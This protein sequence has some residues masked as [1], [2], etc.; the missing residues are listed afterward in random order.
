MDRDNIRSP[1]QRQDDFQH[2]ARFLEVFHQAIET[3]DF[4][5]LLDTIVDHG[6]QFG[7]AAAGILYLY[8]ADRDSYVAAASRG[9]EVAYDKAGH[10]VL[11]DECHLQLLQGRM[12]VVDEGQRWFSQAAAEGFAD[13]SSAVLI[14]FLWQTR[15]TAVLVLLFSVTR[16]VLPDSAAEL[17][18]F[19]AGQAAV[20]IENVRLLESEQQRRIEAEMLRSASI[21]IT[22]TLSLEEVLDNILINL[23]KVISYDRAAVFLLNGSHLFAQAC[24]GF[25]NPEELIGK[26]FPADDEIFQ[27]IRQSGKSLILEDARS[28]P[29]FKGWAGTEQICSWMG[30]PLLVNN[31]TIGY[32]TCDSFQ[33]GIYNQKAASVA[34]AFANQAAMSITNA[35]LYEA[36]HKARQQAEILREVARV[37]SSSLDIEKIL[38]TVLEQ[39]QRILTFDR[40]SVILFD[41]KGK[42]TLAAGMGFKNKSLVKRQIRCRLAESRIIQRMNES[43]SPVLIKD[44]RQDPDWISLTEGESVRS[45][46][47]VPLVNRGSAIGALLIDSHQEG[48]FIEADLA[49]IE[50]LAQHLTVAIENARLFEA[51]R[52]QLLLSKT[53][54]EVGALLT[55]K[56]SLEEVLEQILDLLG[57]VVHYDSASIQ[58]LNAKNRLELTAGRGF[59][60]INIARQIVDELSSHTLK[61]HWDKLEVIPDTRK[62]NRWLVYPGSEYI[63]SWIGAPLLVKGR[64]IGVLNVDSSIPN[65]FDSRAGET[66]MAFANQAA[67]A[68]ENARLFKAERAAR[69]RAE[70]FMEAARVIGASLSLQDVLGTVLDQIQRVLPYDSA[71]VMLV[72]GSQI[73]V[74]AYRGYEKFGGEELAKNVSFD[75]LESETAGA[76]VRQNLPVVVVDTHTD[77]RWARRESMQYIRSWLGVPLSVRDQV[78]GVLSL[79]RCQ[80]GGFS[81]EEVQLARSF[82][83][84]T[85]A[86]IEN[87]RLFEK[88]AKERRHLSLLYDVGR[89]L[90][91]SL[92]PFVILQS[93]ITLTCQTLGG[94]IGNAFLYDPVEDR[95]HLVALSGR[96]SH[97]LPELNRKL[98]MKPGVGLA[99]WAAQNRIAAYAPDVTRDPR[100]KHV[101][102]AEGDIEVRSAMAAPILDGE[103]LL[104][105]ITVMHTSPD[106]FD[107]DQLEL[108]KA[109]CQ[110]LALAL[111]N[112]NSYQLVERRLA[113]ITL[114]QNLSQ[115]FA[116]RLEKSKLLDEVVIQLAGRFDYSQVEIYI[117]E[118]G[119]LVLKAFWGWPPALEPAD[120]E[121]GIIGRA[122]REQHSIL[123][124]N[125]AQDQA[126]EFQP[127]EPAAEL[128]V[129]IFQGKTVL[130]VIHIVSNQPGQLG[131]QDQDLIEVLAGQISIAYENATLYEHLRQHAEELEQ[132]VAQRTSEL[133]ELYRLSEGIGYCFSHGDL[134]RLLL[135][136][137]RSAVHSEIAAACL[138]TSS[139]EGIIVETGRPLNPQVLEWI[140]KTCIKA[141]NRDID[142]KAIAKRLPVNLLEA[143]PYL[144]QAAPVNAV[145]AFIQAP[146]IIEREVVGVLIVAQETSGDFGDDQKRLLTTFANQAGTAVQRLASILWTQQQNLES[147]VEHLPMGILLVDQDFNILV[148]NP[149]GKEILN[150]IN[151]EGTNG[152]LLKLGPYALEE[153]IE[154]HQDSVPFEISLDSDHRHLFSVQI[155]PM[156]HGMQ[157]WVILMRDITQERENQKRIQNQERLATVGQLAA[158]IAHDF[159]NI[160]AAITVYADLLY[161]DPGIRPAGQEKLKIIQQQVQRAASL[162]RQILDFSRRSIMEQSALDLLPLVKEIDKMLRRVLPE[163]IHL[164]LNYQP[165]SYWV[166][167]DPTRLQQV[168]MNLAVNARDAM[169]N[170]GLLEFNLSRFSLKPGDS[171]PVPNMAPGNWIRIDVS[172]NG[173]GI[174]EEVMPHIYDPFFTTKPVGQGTGLGL[175]QVYGIIQQHNGHIEVTSE[176]NKGT[177][178]SIFLPMLEI[179]SGGMYQS[180]DAKA[181]RGKGETV[182]V[183]EDDDATRSAISALL[184]TQNYRVIAARNGI[185]AIEAF[186]QHAASIGLVISDVVMPEMGGIAL[187]RALQER[188][189]GVKMLFITGHPLET[190]GKV[191]LEKGSVN[192]LQKPFTVSDFN[193]AIHML[194]S[195]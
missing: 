37:V 164:S 158:G 159:N 107:A 171:K 136:H 56:L 85:S 144:P 126:P 125:V 133:T 16:P 44:V 160:M 128:A 132:V 147:L 14:P 153:L 170:G 104:G 59:P 23:E 30:I 51:E 79:D 151:S 28:D 146:I 110:E 193:H 50:T 90:T 181:L 179:S 168:F 172:D 15:V 116:Q 155:H 184:E 148:S 177:T 105:A 8:D 36:E 101:S 38:S 99:G 74:Q 97:L 34:E 142:R 165:G 188:S 75:I 129:P 114:I 100:W 113:E 154:Q 83:V 68:I 3:S 166:E 27:H 145:G 9:V 178:F 22:A 67:I 52:E 119:R 152:R 98:A 12:V 91:R 11:P 93:A 130:G 71:S 66:V 31:Q 25:A 174:P 69:S 118:E 26:E 61:N 77:P 46:L 17:M 47:G 167:A 62:D 190:N 141:F 33:K 123:E 173:T 109:I 73:R 175:A 195:E 49:M 135:N 111:S 58:L 194:I 29:R 42:P 139:F 48:A 131:Q 161:Q 6:I 43:L 80:P 45:F 60:D 64:F 186:D 140:K 176:E 121:A 183:V 185:E 2:T 53:L 157:R 82:A 4:S 143:S 40:A 32:L 163:T 81:D 94:H 169:P 187:Y 112:A 138:I 5:L 39:I 189:P 35:R 18:P 70:A 72:E 86:A 95:L 20:V 106:A 120:I 137:M 21:A 84:H 10:L 65:E 63:R 78:I 149:H 108:L 54:Q 127:L 55:S 180:A 41:S 162:I 102:I 134:V 182:L 19:F 87:A 7:E 115:T 24:R 191:M 124:I 192:W 156:L 57:K 88:A 13:F 96:D 76:V 117:Q 122:L 92:D 1:D 89:E 150:I 103:R